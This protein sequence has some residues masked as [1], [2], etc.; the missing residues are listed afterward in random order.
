MPAVRIQMHLRGDSS[1][2]QGFIV[3][4]RVLYAVHMAENA[5]DRKIEFIFPLPSTTYKLR[6]PIPE[7]PPANLVS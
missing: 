4:K 2:L 1:L 6:F 5:G 3:T 7:F